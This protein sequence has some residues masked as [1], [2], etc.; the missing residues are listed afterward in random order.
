MS[1]ILLHDSAPESV[2]R[3]LTEFGGRN[4]YGK[5][6]WRLVR[7]ESRTH[8][9]GGTFNSG[10]SGGDF[11]IQ[12]NGKFGFSE[13]TIQKSY[14]GEDEIRMYGVKGWILERWLPPYV[15]DTREN[16]N[17]R[18]AADGLTPLFGEYPSEG[19]YWMLSGPW[20]EIPPLTFLEHEIS[21]Y[22]YTRNNFS[23]DFE[24]LLREQIQQE[25]TAAEAQYNRMIDQITA[26][27]REV[28]QVM[29]S[30]SLEA[31]RVR[32][33]AYQLMGRKDHAPL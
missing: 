5:P 4:Q 22:E 9:C 33:Q 12:Q 14:N 19:D 10:V 24:K 13:S 7:A 15:W 32:Q 29:L 25:Q 21:T 26:I 30:G 3:K 1:T 8:V 31:Q 27:G 17:S 11:Q 28:R 16:W 23:Q 18:K 20:P 6:L 2:R